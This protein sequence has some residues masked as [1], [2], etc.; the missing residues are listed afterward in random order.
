LPNNFASDSSC[1]ALWKFDN[2]TLKYRHGNT[3]AACEAASW[4]TYTIPFTSLGFVQVR[5]ESTL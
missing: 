5:I 3:I 2:V 4:N 1:K